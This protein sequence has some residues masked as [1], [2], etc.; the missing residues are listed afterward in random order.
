MNSNDFDRDLQNLFNKFFKDLKSSKWKK[1]LEIRSKEEYEDLAFKLSG[2][3]NKNDF[4]NDINRITTDSREFSVNRDS[5]IISHDT[6][7]P[8]ILCHTSG[9]TD[10][11]IS[12]LKWFHMNNEIIKRIWIPGMN[13][14]FESSGL[15]RD[16]SSVIFVPSRIETD[17]I[18]KIEDKQYISLYSSEFS[19]RLAISVINPK[20][21]LFHEYKEAKN[22][23]VIFKLL[24]MED[25]SVISA[26]ATTIIGWADVDKFKRGILTNLKLNENNPVKNRNILHEV[27]ENE[28]IHKGSRK[29]QNLLS[30]KLSNA[31]LIF[32]ISNLSES[33]W[34]LISKFM[35]WNNGKKNFTNLYVG[36]EIGP[37]ACSLTNDVANKNQLHVLPLTIPVIENKGKRELIS[38]TNARIGNLLVSYSINSQN[39]I[40]I[41]TGDVISIE[42]KDKGL[43]IISG[44]ILR[45]KFKLKYPIKI[46][47]EIEKFQEYDVFAGHYFPFEDFEIENPKKIIEC[48]KKKTELKSDSLLLINSDKNSNKYK[49]ILSVYNKNNRVTAQEL[50]KQILKCELG[51]KIKATI[52]N[53]KLQLKLVKDPPVDYMESR[54]EI[55]S[56]V[57]SGLIPKGILK[58]WPLYVLE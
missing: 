13:A 1:W 33:Q 15:T 54:E 4:L 27:I 23:D 37:F 10:S 38:I 7:E 42:K 24:S 39:R 22:L 3:G 35:R 29:I 56:R 25:I 12:N 14:I 47:P 26:P 58:K 49:L 18:K 6:S 55:L 34:D 41:D 40:N 31:R 19:Q 9:T 36:S 30:D 17:G 8:L 5:F 53:D 44:R 32:S 20:N 45:N 2:I 43:P 50:T 57:R 52:Q 48:L 46:S 16:T 21:Y 51:G 11:K 28:G